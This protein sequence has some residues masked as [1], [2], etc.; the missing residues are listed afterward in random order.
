MTIF[1]VIV[2]A[3]GGFIG[4]ILRYLIS[5]KMNRKDGFPIGTL[6]V[7]LV[8]SLLIGF[9][10][11]LDLSRISTIF[12]VSGFAG[13]LTT[14][15]TLNKELVLLWK[16]SKKRKF[17]YYLMLTYVVGILFGYFGYLLGAIR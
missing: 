15:S 12:L 10:F 9:I 11:G 1:E 4:A 8:G 13:A 3:A 2:I 6:V 7:N 14:F 5:R 16:G 17:F